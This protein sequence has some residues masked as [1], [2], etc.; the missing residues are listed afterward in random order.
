MLALGF[1]MAALRTTPNIVWEGL[2]AALVGGL[3]SSI[4]ESV[5]A[6]EFENAKP[7]QVTKEMLAAKIDELRSSADRLEGHRLGHAYRIV[8]SISRKP[9]QFYITSPDRSRLAGFR[10]GG[11][12]CGPRRSAACPSNRN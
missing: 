12:D 2:A 3:A 7:P 1:Q 11:R 5:M 10:L 8:S 9:Y 4:I 6:N